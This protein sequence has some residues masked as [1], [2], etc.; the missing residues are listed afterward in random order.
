MLECFCL[1]SGNSARV[2][3]RTTRTKKI[4]GMDM[5]IKGILITALLLGST[6]L[7]AW[8]GGSQ[9]AT[10]RTAYSDGRT[11]LLAAAAEAPFKSGI[12]ARDAGDFDQAV[13]AFTAAIKLDAKYAEAYYERGSAYFKLK[14]YEQA[15]ADFAKVIELKPPGLIVEAYNNR[16]VIYNDVQQKYPEAIADFTKALQIDP[17][18]VR[19]YFNRAL[20]SDRSGKGDLAIADYSKALEIDGQNVDA[21][22]N[23]GIVYLE[24]KQP[25]KALADFSKAVEIDPKY[26]LG[27]YNLG[28]T[29]ATLK[30]FDESLDNYTR[31]IAANPSYAQAYHNRGYIYNDIRKDYPKALAD[32]D[33]ALKLNPE[34][35]NAYYNRGLAYYNQHKYTQALGDFSEVLKRNPKDA[36]A[37]Y[38][39]GECNYRISQWDP[40]IE[41]FKQVIQLIPKDAWSYYWLARLYSYKRDNDNAL[42]A[43]RQAIGYNPEFKKQAQTEAD[44]V[45]LRNLPEFKQLTQ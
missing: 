25:D 18:Y 1:F 43:L 30:K 11:L 44:L 20:A 45:F 40:A 29:Y 41:D 34:Y 31:A 21:F 4:K 8:A 3:A 6:P 24:L 5:H 19:A 22:N 27:Y 42:A 15:L 36:D 33:Q 17:T 2:T 39:H 23:R 16:G 32:F 9:P 35:L 38:Y 14:A 13:T 12:K 28:M 37:Y 26:A 7:A 10:E